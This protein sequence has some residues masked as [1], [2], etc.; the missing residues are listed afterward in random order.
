MDEDD[1]FANHLELLNTKVNK[2]LRSRPDH[3]VGR[4]EVLGLDIITSV[5]Q[6][7]IIPNAHFSLKH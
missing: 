7:I 4:K 2:N 5:F 3:Q 1:Y 6:M